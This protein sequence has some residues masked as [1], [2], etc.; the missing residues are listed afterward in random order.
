MTKEDS[1]QPPIQD[2]PSSTLLHRSCKTVSLAVFVDC[3]FNSAFES[4]LISGKATTEELTSVWHEIYYEYCDLIRSKDDFL[5]NIMKKINGLQADATFIDAAILLLSFRPNVD[6]MNLLNSMGFNIDENNILDSLRSAQTLASR[7]IWDIDEAKAELN[8][9]LQSKGGEMKEKD[10]AK[11]IA[12]VAKY[13]GYH[14]DKNTT[15]VYD[16]TMIYN[17]FCEDIDIKK[18][19]SA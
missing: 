6:S 10:F 3:M 18:R 11:N 7:I 2:I 8:N 19:N 12:M 1:V 16:Y 17:N 14:I 4:L 5:L 15:S 9:Y 13:Q